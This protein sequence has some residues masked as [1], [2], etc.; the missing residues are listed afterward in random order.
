MPHK[1]IDEDLEFYN[2][3][4]QIEKTI[5]R[6]DKNNFSILKIIFRIPYQKLSEKWYNNKILSILMTSSEKFI[7]IGVK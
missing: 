2:G 1:N 3:R 6:L 7:N 5:S 4:S